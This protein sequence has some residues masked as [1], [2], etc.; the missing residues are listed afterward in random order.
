MAEERDDHAGAARAMT[1]LA[2]VWG[3]AAIA[4]RIGWTIDGIHPALSIPFLLAE[5]WLLVRLGL[6]A[7]TT[8]RTPTPSAGGATT[9]GRSVDL[10]VR[11]DVELLVPAA[12]ASA[13]AVGRTLVLA[14]LDQPTGV[15]VLDETYR[16]DV[17]AEARRHGASY[18]ILTSIEALASTGAPDTHGDP[19][20]RLVG[21][22]IPGAGSA[23]VAWIDA[24]DLPM[25][26]FLDLASQFRDPFV[27]VVQAG[28]D[29]FDG[30]NLVRSLAHC[31][32]R[33]IQDRVVGPTLGRVGA[34]PWTGSGSLVRV[35]AMEEIDGLP[36]GSGS[37]TLRATTRLARAGWRV[38]YSEQRAVRVIAPETTRDFLARTGTEAE[39]RWRAL[40]T[41]DSPLFTA[42]M[43]LRTRL[44]A[45]SVATRPLDGLARLLGLI[46]LAI[47]LVSGHL[48]LHATAPMIAVV[49]LPALAL[50]SAAIVLL[51]RGTLRWGDWT[52]H[53]LRRMAT[54]LR[55]LIG[56]PDSHGPDSHGPAAPRLVTVLTAALGSALLIRLATP[57]LSG[58][59][60]EPSG[61][62]RILLIGAAI[63]ALCQLSRVVSSGRGPRSRRSGE[64]TA[65]ELVAGVNGVACRAVDLTPTGLA[66]DLTAVPDIG[67]RLA[68]DLSVPRADGTIDTLE[69]VGVVRH[70]SDTADQRGATHRVGVE[71]VA[72]TA[73]SRDALVE[74]C[75][76][77][78]EERDS[79]RERRSRLT[80][81]RIDITGAGGSQFRRRSDDR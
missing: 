4:W 32:E 9:A 1:A 37:A 18:Q 30:D 14:A 67:D 70:V 54:D 46:A 38:Q 52:R 22:A 6:F 2:L 61:V 73:A 27:G 64:R 75:A 8:W 47:A 10:T 50:R 78:A 80:E 57:A 79:V 31:D 39:K 19:N 25:P 62:D 53:G 74:M 34:A 17:A 7:V 5:V 20:A 16:D 24:G 41:T 55:S 45:I 66:V 63:A 48:P 58:R 60:P 28:T 77:T 23:I 42:D 68:I 81:R 40:F 72:P 69:L 65:T 44:A 71:L 51:A 56:R 11:P 15:R 21:R 43:R 33:D 3:I 49:W 13:G 26:G 59:G 36:E 35:L 76:L 29:Y 12:G